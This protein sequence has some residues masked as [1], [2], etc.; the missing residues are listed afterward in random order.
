MMSSFQ[1]PHSIGR[2]NQ[3]HSNSGVA[4]SLGAQERLDLQAQSQAHSTGQG[5]LLYS[6]G[7]AHLN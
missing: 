7:S 5:G 1:Q 2:A 3:L 6:G 4:S